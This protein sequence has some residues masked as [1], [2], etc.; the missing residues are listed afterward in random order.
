MAEPLPMPVPNDQ[1]DG[2]T[3]RGSQG[4]KQGLKPLRTVGIQSFQLRQKPQQLLF[5][6]L[7]GKGSVAGLK[8]PGLAAADQAIPFQPE[9]QTHHGTGGAPADREGH[10]L[11]ERKPSEGPA[12]RHPAVNLQTDTTPL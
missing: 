5:H 3:G 11:G 12:H 9:L 10:G 1:V 8:S 2:T 7:K 6:S 4:C